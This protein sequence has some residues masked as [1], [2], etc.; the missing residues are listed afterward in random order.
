MKRANKPIAVD[1]RVKYDLQIQDLL[2][3]AI[4]AREKQEEWKAARRKR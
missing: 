3:E 1:P 2:A 4:S